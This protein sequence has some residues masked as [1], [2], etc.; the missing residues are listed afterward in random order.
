[1]N[2]GHSHPSSRC[3]VDGL[4][5]HVGST[6]VP[7]D[8]PRVPKEPLFV[9]AFPNPAG[10][11]IREIARAIPECRRKIHSRKTDAGVT[12]YIMVPGYAR[13]DVEL[14]WSDDSL[15]IKLA[16]LDKEEHPWACGKCN[17]TKVVSLAKWPIDPK[18]IKAK[19]ENGILVIDL[20]FREEKQPFKIEVE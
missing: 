20:P 14:K 5:Y 3:I 10:L 18:K 7:F 11:S 13:D 19:V 16:E 2:H 15:V 1:M 12:L 6:F 8:N 4:S 9:P 17:E